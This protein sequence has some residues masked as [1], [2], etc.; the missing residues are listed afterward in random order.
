[1]K[2]K[3]TWKIYLVLGTV[4]VASAILS[5]SLNLSEFFKGL[6]SIPAV[7]ALSG[8]IVQI[9]RD[10]A[11]YE[12]V[13]MLQQ[14]QQDYSLGVTSHMANLTFDKHVEFC[15]AYMTQMTEGFAK[16]MS[17]GPT[18]DAAGIALGLKVLRIKYV[19]WISPDVYK[20]LELFEQ[21]L[22][23]I[24]ML[25]PIGGEVPSNREDVKALEEAQHLF[26]VITGDKKTLAGNE[27]HIAITK[28]IEHLQGILG[29]RELFTLR[30]KAM[31]DAL[32]R[33]KEI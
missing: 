23:D 28:V 12:R 21:A 8:V 16:L 17:Q 5:I 10:H 15:E 25:S 32:S 14:Q 4:V 29:I 26:D 9:F 6:L 27:D 3:L 24:G 2:L 1:V 11:A 22:F 19:T 33:I 30:K 20:N 7:G 31:L 13:Q 18:P